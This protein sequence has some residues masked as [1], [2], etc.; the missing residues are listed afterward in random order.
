MLIRHASVELDVSTLDWRRCV[1][2]RPTVFTAEVA[3]Q[4]TILPQCRRPGTLPHMWSDI[5]AGSAAAPNNDTWP[6]RLCK[7]LQPGRKAYN[8]TGPGDFYTKHKHSLDSQISS[9]S[10]D[11]SAL[12][13]GRFKVLT[14]RACDALFGGWVWNTLVEFY[15]EVDVRCTRTEFVG[16]VKEFSWSVPVDPRRWTSPLPLLPLPIL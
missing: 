16:T 13:N 2:T 15:D 12:R 7:A 8:T 1:L 6:A 9:D 3:E 4:L 10:V 14:S 5:A 11:S